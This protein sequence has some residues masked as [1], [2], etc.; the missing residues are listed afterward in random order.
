MM[1][2]VQDLALREQEQCAATV[3]MQ[4]KLGRSRCAECDEP[5]APM[6]QQM[7]ARLCVDCQTDA[8][9]AAA[10]ARGVRR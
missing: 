8:E 4:A 2:H 9:H 10:I 7:G 6:R 5:I 3:R 1:D